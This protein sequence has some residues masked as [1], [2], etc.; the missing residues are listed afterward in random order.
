[1]ATALHTAEGRSARYLEAGQNPFS[2]E[3]F[4]PVPSLPFEGQAYPLEFPTDHPS[5]SNLREI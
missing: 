5:V 2:E 3:G 1:M 4:R